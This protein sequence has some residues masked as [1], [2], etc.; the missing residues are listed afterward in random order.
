MNRAVRCLFAVLLALHAGFAI[1]FTRSDEL[2]DAQVREA[3]MQLAPGKRPRIIFAGFAMHPDSTAFRGDVQLAEQVMRLIDSGAVVFRLS[4]AV[5]G[6]PRDWPL[7]TRDNIASV[8]RA[9]G[10]AARPEDKVVLLLSSHGLEGLLAVQAESGAIEAIRPRELQS[11]LGP[12]RGK[13]ALVLLSSCFSGSFLPALRG[14][15]RIVLTASSHDRQSFGCKSDSRNTFFI[16]ELF[17]QRDVAARSLVEL[18]D[19]AKGAIEKRERSMNLLPSQPQA[20]W[21]GPAMQA[22]ARQPLAGWLSARTP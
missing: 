3:R 2:L 4:A 14:P 6:Q 5:Y 19:E 20:D 1:G 15:T 11:W 16:E 17:T 21:G 22:W 10:E 13:P 7:A 18:V 8:L 9:I 12:L